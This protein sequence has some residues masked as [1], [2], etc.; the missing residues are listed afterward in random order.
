MNR[1]RKTGVGAL[2]TIGMVGLVLAGYASADIPDSTDGSITACRVSGDAGNT[3]I[4][5]KENGE[6]CHSY[7]DEVT[8]PGTSYNFEP[9]ITVGSFPANTTGI[10]RNV[11]CPAGQ[12]L[13]EARAGER[14][15]DPNSSEYQ[16]YYR[17]G[18]SIDIGAGLP[19]YAYNTNGSGVLTGVQFKQSTYSAIQT[20]IVCT[21]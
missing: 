18:G 16:G 15:Y 12:K 4:I 6:S 13:I 20:V 3:R 19:I 1:L 14:V 5:D 17:S 7:E 9:K 11:D 10:I 8:W 21:P 2:A